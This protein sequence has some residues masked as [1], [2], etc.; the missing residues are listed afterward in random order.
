M[1]LYRVVVGV[2]LVVISCL[3]RLNHLTLSRRL[4]VD[5]RL[6]LPYLRL[7]QLPCVVPVMV[8]MLLDVITVVTGSI[9]HHCVLGSQNSLLLVSRNLV[10]MVLHLYVRNVIVLAM[11]TRV[12]SVTRLFRKFS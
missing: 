3:T 7:L 11:L 12:L 5:I 9:H 1:G 2:G 6:S 4:E 8:K 10:V